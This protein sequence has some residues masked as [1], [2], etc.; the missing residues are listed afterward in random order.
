MLFLASML[1]T[2]MFSTTHELKVLYMCMPM[3][4]VIITGYSILSFINI[5]EGMRTFYIHPPGLALFRLVPGPVLLG[6]NNA[7]RSE[8]KST[9]FSS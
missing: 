9:P 6:L 3:K 4:S 8:D 1:I 2:R 5:R 7:F